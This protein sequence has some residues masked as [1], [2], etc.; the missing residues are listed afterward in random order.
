MINY[1]VSMGS[2]KTKM[3][4][5]LRNQNYQKFLDPQKVADLIINLAFLKINGYTEEIVIKRI[6]N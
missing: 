1:L 5:K 6:I 2:M 4:K 3:G